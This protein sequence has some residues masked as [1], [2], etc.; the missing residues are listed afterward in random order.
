MSAASLSLSTLAGFASI[1]CQWPTKKRCTSTWRTSFCEE[2]SPLPPCCPRACCRGH[3]VALAGPCLVFS[4]V[5]SSYCC[6]PVMTRIRDLHVLKIQNEAVMLSGRKLLLRYK[7][8]VRLNP[9]GIKLTSNN[10]HF[11]WHSLVLFWW[12][13]SWAKIVTVSVLVQSFWFGFGLA[14]NCKEMFWRKIDTLRIGANKAICHASPN[15]V[16]WRGCSCYF[17]PN[18]LHFSVYIV[19]FSYLFGAAAHASLP[20]CFKI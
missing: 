14:L 17:T 8:R 16:P 2:S 13:E 18:F 6:D 7:V 1:L 19:S 4:P 9:K 3:E 15:L 11:S 5:S 20:Y 10:D 12:A